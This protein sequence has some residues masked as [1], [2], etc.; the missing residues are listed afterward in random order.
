MPSLAHLSPKGLTVFTDDHVES[1][2]AHPLKTGRIDEHVESVLYSVMNDTSLV[3]FLNSARGGVNQRDVRQIKC[4][5][6]LIVE[7]GA[8]T[9]VG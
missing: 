6:E 8:F 3:D 9:T 7:S 4:R 1:T 2:C 5:Q